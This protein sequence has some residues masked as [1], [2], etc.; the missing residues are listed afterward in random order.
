MT[1]HGLDTNQPP[2]LLGFK[3]EP[4][5]HTRGLQTNKVNPHLTPRLFLVSLIFVSSWKWSGQ[6]E[7]GY[8]FL[9][10]AFLTWITSILWTHMAL[11]Q[12]WS[13]CRRWQNFIFWAT[14]TRPI[15]CELIQFMTLSQFWELSIIGIK[16]AA[17]PSLFLC[18][19]AHPFCVEE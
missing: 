13:V 15:M 12:L 19:Q 2:L 5:A 18:R 9:L 4:L 6:S 8:E 10:D 16:L 17:S 11:S 14:H 1:W 7:H 3:L